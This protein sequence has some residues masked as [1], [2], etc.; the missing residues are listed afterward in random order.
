MQSFLL[1]ISH[2]GE[3]LSKLSD[4]RSASRQ[5]RT[6]NVKQPDVECEVKSDFGG[7]KKVRKN[8]VLTMNV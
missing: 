1:S 3:R 5:T 4:G 6:E 2:A 8:E 7:K